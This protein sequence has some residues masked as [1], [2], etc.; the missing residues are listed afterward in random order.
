MGGKNPPT[1]V[2]IN[3]IQVFFF[4]SS[5]SSPQLL[6]CRWRSISISAGSL[7]FLPPYFPALTC[8]EQWLP[9]LRGEKLIE[10][11]EAKRKLTTTGW[12]VLLFC[13]ETDAAMPSPEKGDASLGRFLNCLF[14]CFNVYPPRFYGS[15][16]FSEC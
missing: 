4:F 12:L 15:A 8:G 10:S 13:L 16:F 14:V 9:S 6:F 2:W 1:A 3:F 7:G 11:I 5:K